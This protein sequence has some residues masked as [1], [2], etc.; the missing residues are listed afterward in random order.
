MQFL[1][2]MYNF[3]V[4]FMRYTEYLNLKIWS[5]FVFLT[6]ASPH[7]NVTSRS[8]TKGHVRKNSCSSEE[9]QMRS[10]N[11]ITLKCMPTRIIKIHGT[12]KKI[13][14]SSYSKPI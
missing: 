3:G 10:K 13:T 6:A 4:G 5:K 12:V 2:Y 11:A 9:F 14:F 8:Y 7:I 1:I